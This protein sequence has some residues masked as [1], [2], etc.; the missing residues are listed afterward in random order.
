MASPLQA[1]IGCS[2]AGR[3]VATHSCN[4]RFMMRNTLPPL[5]SNDLFGGVCDG[6]ILMRA[7]ASEASASTLSA[8]A[9]ISWCSLIRRESFWT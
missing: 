3:Q 7:K 9:N 6:H 1:S 8:R 2:A 4:V 5:A